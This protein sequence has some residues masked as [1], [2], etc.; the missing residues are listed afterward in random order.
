LKP[1]GIGAVSLARFAR[2]G[3]FFPVPELK[4]RLQQVLTIGPAAREQHRGAQQVLALGAEKFL[5]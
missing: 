2:V 3:V 4:R 5:K 1:A